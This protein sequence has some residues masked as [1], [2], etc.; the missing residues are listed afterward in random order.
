MTEP[1][2][3]LRIDSYTAGTDG[4]G[5][6][7]TYAAIM[8]SHY[9]YRTIWRIDESIG[10][11]GKARSVL[12]DVTAAAVRELARLEAEHKEWARGCVA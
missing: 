11:T 9:C 12:D 5:E 6:R 10:A 1:R 7:R 8:D 3:T 2:Y 4:K